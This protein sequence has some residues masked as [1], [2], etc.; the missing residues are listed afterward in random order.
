[1]GFMGRVIGWMTRD[2]R[3]GDKN[4][5]KYR[6]NSRDVGVGI[7]STVGGGLVGDMR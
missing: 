5:E 1:M 6:N 4:V 7:L 2:E 3:V